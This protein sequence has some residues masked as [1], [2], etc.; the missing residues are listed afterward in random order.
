MKTIMKAQAST[1]QVFMVGKLTI[2]L[3]SEGS[4]R[5]QERTVSNGG[6]IGMN[7]KI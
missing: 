2:A 7:V 5:V 4:L 3:L 1:S 6:H